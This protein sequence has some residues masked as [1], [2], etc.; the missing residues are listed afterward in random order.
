MESVLPSATQLCAGCPVKSLKQARIDT[1]V[2]VDIQKRIAEGLNSLLEK[3]L[4]PDLI[5]G[6]GKDFL[7]IVV[8][9]W[10]TLNSTDKMKYE[11]SLVSSCNR[12]SGPSSSQPSAISL[13][14]LIG[15]II[16]AERF[17]L[18]NLLTAAIDLASKCRFMKLRNEKRYR[19]IT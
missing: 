5:A 15:Y 10:D 16:A 14:T 3:E 12:Q 6:S 19:R 7:K 9:L 13:H 1:K 4:K 18:E 2:S 17:N 8:L 11:D